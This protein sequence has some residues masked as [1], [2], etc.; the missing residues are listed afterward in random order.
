MRVP[1]NRDPGWCGYRS[2]TVRV[3]VSTSHG[4]NGVW[5][6]SSE[7][8]KRRRLPCRRRRLARWLRHRR[9]LSAVPIHGRRYGHLPLRGCRRRLRSGDVPHG[10]RVWPRPA[11]H[12]LRER[13][14][15]RTPRLRLPVPARH[16]WRRQGLHVCGL[17]GLW[18]RPRHDRP[19][20]QRVRRALKV[21]C[22]QRVPPRLDVSGIAS[23]QVFAGADA[24]CAPPPAARRARTRRPESRLARRARAGPPSAAA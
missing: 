24:T 23:T 21:A 5:P 6:R 18:L 10:L 12:E 2:R 7:P 19:R 14:R 4:G 13:P 20:M 22:T 9:E 11:L 3:R 15:L 17:Q 16:V 8:G 1:T